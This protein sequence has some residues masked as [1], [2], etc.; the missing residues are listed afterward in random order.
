[1]VCLL[2]PSLIAF[3]PLFKSITDMF[4]SCR[5]GLTC[6]KWTKLSISQLC[7]GPAVTASHEGGAE[8]WDHMII[9]IIP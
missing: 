4:G 6:A 5:I 7:V 8:T 3:K 2:M 9:I 1:M